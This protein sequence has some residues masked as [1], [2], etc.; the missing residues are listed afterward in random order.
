MAVLYFHDEK[1]SFL[2]SQE[3]ESRK[4]LVL[5]VVRNMS[6]V[7]QLIGLLLSISIL[8]RAGPRNGNNLFSNR[9]CFNHLYVYIADK[10][11]IRFGQYFLHMVVCGAVFLFLYMPF[12]KFLC[13]VFLKQV[14]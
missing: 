3:V 10:L 6:S 7:L 5:Q 11:P 12:R 14:R 13:Q 9:F 2:Y 4:H 8:C 1:G